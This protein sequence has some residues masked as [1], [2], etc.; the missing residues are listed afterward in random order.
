MVTYVARYV[1]KEDGAIPRVIPAKHA[2]PLVQ[3]ATRILQIARHVL[4]NFT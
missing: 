2:T 1:L 4:V 3:P